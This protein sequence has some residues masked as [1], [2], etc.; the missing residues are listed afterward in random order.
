MLPP[1]GA[2][3]IKA[4]NESDAMPSGGRETLGPAPERASRVRSVL[5]TKVW[6]VRWGEDL[7]LELINYTRLA[8]SLCGSTSPNRLSVTSGSRTA[9]KTRHGHASFL[10]EST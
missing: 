8:A 5:A 7:F 9:R 4:N 3:V 6:R 1:H 10:K 2:W